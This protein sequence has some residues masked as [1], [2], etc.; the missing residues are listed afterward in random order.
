M[1]TRA[2]LDR[3]QGTPAADPTPA[4]P[5]GDTLAE[6]TTR[7]GLVLFHPFLVLLFQRLDLLDDA[8]RIRPGARLTARAAL[9]ALADPMPGPARLTDPIER[10]LLGLPR[11]WVHPGTPDPAPPAPDLTDSL[12]RAV[13]DRWGALGQTAPEGLRET[14]VRRTGT[15]T[16]TDTGPRLAVD[17]GPFD[18]LLDR[19]PW[20]LSTVALPWMALPLTV[21]WR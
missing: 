17:P 6:P 2:A 13:I 14:F 18:M 9:R 8:R 7:A 20:G 5:T 3:L 4:A 15:L 12:T 21:E 16:E 11:G 1:E 10:V 19:L